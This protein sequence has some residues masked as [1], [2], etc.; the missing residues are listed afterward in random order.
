VSGGSAVLVTGGSGF[1]G[2]ALLGRLVAQGRPV[3]AL[4][5][6][7]A[8]AA[9]VRARGAEPVRGDLRDP[10]ALRRALRA[11]AV[12][13][14]VAGL[15]AHCLRDSAPLWQVNVDG[16]R[17]LLDAAAAAGV[18]RVVHTSSA[19]T[20]GEVRGT[21]GA[22]DTPHRGWHLSAYERSKHEGE[23]LA[24]AHAA[25]RGIEL[26]VVNPASVQGPGRSRGSARLLAGYLDGRLPFVVDTQLSLVDVDDC[27]AG[28]VRAEAHGRAGER[29]LL[30][31]ATLGVRE[32]L[33]LLAAVT[34]VRRRPRRLPAPV[35]RAGAL[36]GE[37][38]ARLLGRDA[39]VCRETVATLLHG[40]AYD[41]SKAT[42]ELG[43]VYTPVE[44][45][46]RRTLRWLAD[47]AAL[48][49]SGR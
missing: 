41:G 3:R 20:I 15:N 32:A 8:T 40:H 21:V 24:L 44:V 4:C 43:L 19:A 49:P 5:R 42:R 12:V 46:L 28:H 36:A 22:E 11:V 31:G 6:S 45:T 1:V 16:T 29:Y 27:A 10:G 39:A 13:Y 26:V 17:R 18:A 9:R 30:S 37:G 2:G 23:Q 38:L 14:H 48:R 25:A 35:A 47:V 34:G 33:D 7:E